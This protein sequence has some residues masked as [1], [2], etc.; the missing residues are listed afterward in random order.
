LSVLILYGTT[1]G[2]T[3][4]VA[5]ALARSLRLSDDRVHVIDA[6]EGDPNPS[7]Y[8]AVI[9]AASVLSVA[10][11]PTL[12]GGLVSAAGRHVALENPR[13]RARNPAV[14]DGR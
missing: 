8:S 7:S 3:R 11:N 13:I 2:H 14:L 12:H 9:V 1:E 5:E 10:A 6:A 4:S